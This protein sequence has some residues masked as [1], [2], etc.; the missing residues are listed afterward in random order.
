MLNPHC[1]YYNARPARPAGQ[2]PPIP[3]ATVPD[4]NPA[5]QRRQAG[6]CLDPVLEGV[7]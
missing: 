1:K 5:G 6:R 7:V 3:P 4:R 2:R